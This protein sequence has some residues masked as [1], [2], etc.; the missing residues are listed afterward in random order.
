MLLML[1]VMRKIFTSLFLFSILFISACSSSIESVIEGDDYIPDRR[2]DE[3]IKD[4]KNIKDQI[5]TII[6]SNTL[7]EDA[8][9]KFMVHNGVVLIVGE[10][11]NLTDMEYLQTTIKAINALD[12]K[13]IINQVEV[14]EDNYTYLDRAQD[15]MIGLQ[16]K[17]L[18]MEQEDIDEKHVNFLI[19]RKVM[20]LMGVL[21]K[22][23]AVIVTNHLAETPGVER[24]VVA[25]EYIKA[26]PPLEEE[27]YQRKENYQ[28]R[29]ADIEAKKQELI[30]QQEELQKELYLLEKE[31]Y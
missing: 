8:R 9:L 12:I 10:V 5:K 17:T 28:Q 25:F 20:Y 24:F 4:D 22:K 30:Q 2:G 7:L 13:K 21:T 3:V 15:L 29:K 31:N 16:A 14:R 23:E 1:N 19:Y 18:L 27:Y 26:R 11:D 6:D